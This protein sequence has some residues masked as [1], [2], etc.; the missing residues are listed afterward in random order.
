[1]CRIRWSDIHT[2]LPNWDTYISFVRQIPNSDKERDNNASSHKSTFIYTL[3]W[4]QTSRLFLTFRTLLGSWQT[5]EWKKPRIKYTRFSI[6]LILSSQVCVCVVWCDLYLT[7]CTRRQATASNQVA[8][9]CTCSRWVEG[10]IFT[11]FFICSFIFCL[12]A[13]RMNDVTWSFRCFLLGMMIT[14]L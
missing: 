5:T 6:C 3:Q 1:M 11:S 10:E 9:I 8:L 4:S 12:S 7:C 2:N 13:Y 14:V